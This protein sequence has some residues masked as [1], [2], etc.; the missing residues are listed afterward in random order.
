[1]VGAQRYNHHTAS[2]DQDPNLTGDLLSLTQSRTAAPS[3]NK[4]DTANAF[5]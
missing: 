5:D 3:F 4:V 1:M 2:Y